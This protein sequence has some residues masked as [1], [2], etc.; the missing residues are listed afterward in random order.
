MKLELVL[1]GCLLEL[2]LR[3]MSSEFICIVVLDRLTRKTN[4][5]KN[6]NGE[7]NNE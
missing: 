1:N 4:P 2:R 5:N 6:K 3:V 7:V